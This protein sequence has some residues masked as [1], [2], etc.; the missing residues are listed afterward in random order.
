MTLDLPLYQ[1][2][3]L[4]AHDEHGE[5]LIHRP[6]LGLGLTGA[7]L[8][9][10]MLDKR[11]ALQDNQAWAPDAEPCGDLVTDTLVRTVGRDGARRPLA[12]WLREGT[13]GMY[14]QVAHV[15]TTSGQVV[16]GTYRRLGLRRQVMIPTDPVIRARMQTDLLH[17]YH[18]RRTGGPSWAAL[19][20]LIGV[21]RL[22]RALDV[23]TGTH[24]TLTRLRWIANTQVPD[25]AAV[26]AAIKALHGDMALAAY[27]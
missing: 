20:G 27:R 9:D 4:T 1:A 16:P 12:A 13:A 22:Q 21:L 6:S 3:F 17:V 19:C 25:C 7:A 11:L 23:E 14:G 5:P 2:L 10:L 24:E 26:L 15:L 8:L 18:G